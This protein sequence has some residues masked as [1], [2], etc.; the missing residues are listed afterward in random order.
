MSGEHVF[1]PQKKKKYPNLSKIKN[2]IN[3]HRSK[4]EN[5]ENSRFLLSLKHCRIAKNGWNEL[6]KLSS[7]GLHSLVSITGTKFTLKVIWLELWCKISVFHMWNIMCTP[8]NSSNTWV[9]WCNV[10]YLVY[11]KPGCPIL[12]SFLSLVYIFSARFGKKI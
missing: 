9:N 5:F 7:G 3:N 11:T 6:K 8:V 1:Y 12:L 2:Y 4:N 10:S